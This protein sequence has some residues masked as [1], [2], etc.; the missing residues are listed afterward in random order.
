MND[1]STL[2]VTNQHE[3]DGKSSRSSAKQDSRKSKFVEKQSTS[4]NKSNIGIYQIQIL[5]FKKKFS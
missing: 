1:Q 2:S 3:G 5:L 4:K